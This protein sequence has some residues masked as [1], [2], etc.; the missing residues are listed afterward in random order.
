MYNMVVLMGEAGAGK[1]SMMQAV[2]EKLAER[3]HVADVH[4]IVSVIFTNEDPVGILTAEG[5]LLLTTTND[6]RAIGRVAKGV[7]GIKL[8]EGDYVAS[9]K[10]LPKNTKEILSITRKGLS[11]RTG[12]DEFGFTGKNT[13]GKKV[14]KITDGDLMADFLAIENEPEV[15]VVSSTA[16]LKVS[17]LEISSLGRG[18]QGSKTIKLK[19]TDKVISLLKI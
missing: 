11:K 10:I 7:K 19:E 5:N 4:E 8:N 16:Q 15:L 14:Q 17:T 12:F 18:A 9:A 2:L 6:I 1:D 3:G 13:K